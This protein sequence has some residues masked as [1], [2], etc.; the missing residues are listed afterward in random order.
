MKSNPTQRSGELSS[1]AASIPE[2]IGPPDSDPPSDR[3]DPYPLFHEHPSGDVEIEVPDDG[4]RDL[5]NAEPS[6][7]EMLRQPP[8]SLDFALLR[9]ALEEISFGVATTRSGLILYANAALERLYGASRGGLERKHV[10]VLFD[11]ETFLRLSEQLDERRVF[12]GRIHTQGLNGQPIDAEVHAEWYSSEALGI[13]G[14]LVF[15]DV[16]M[17][18][19]ALGRLVDQVGGVLFRVNTEDGTLEYVSPAIHKMVGLDPSSCIEHPVL[20]TNLVSVD[21]RSRIAFLFKRLVSG[22]ITTANAQVS[23]RRP[24]GKTKLIQLRATAR[25]DTSGH[26]RHLDGVATEGTREGVEALQTQPFEVP[27]Q[28]PQVRRRRDNVNVAPAVMEVAEELLRET[29]Q[30]LHTLN[31]AVG[32]A[33]G[34]IDR[35]PGPRTATAVMLREHLGEMNRAVVAAGSLNRRIRRA[36]AGAT[37]RSTLADVLEQCA[38]T[39]RRVIGA[40]A[41]GLDLGDAAAVLIEQRVD[42]IIL[43]LVYLGIRAFRLVGSGTLK[44]EVQ[45]SFP[46][47]AEP[48]GKSRHLGDAPEQQDTLILIT[49]VAPAD[50]SLPGVEISAEM[51][52]LTRPAESDAAFNAAKALLALCD[53]TIEIDDLKIDEVSTVIRLRG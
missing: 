6:S 50:S 10:R 16:S 20:L 9:G 11:Q 26:V 25:R 29:S 22:E 24:D 44:I 53:G 23:V 28:R 13:G 7:V 2:V 46:I 37:A 39:L 3:T 8:A 21:E 49:G 32:D 15:R 43:V 17:E 12:D 36:M 47:P 40:G 48:R 35:E 14:F 27:A 18:L 41:L 34:E 52:T 38:H 33:Q 30:H 19:G 45:R 1:T 5:L 42:E 31:R 51:Q 4:G